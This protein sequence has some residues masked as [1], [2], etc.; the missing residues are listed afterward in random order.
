MAE[1]LSVLIPYNFVIHKAGA[2]FLPSAVSILE[3]L[4]SWVQDL[5]LYV[6]GNGLL[7]MTK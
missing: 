7:V 3:N 6:H 4:G 1:G 2:G 5:G